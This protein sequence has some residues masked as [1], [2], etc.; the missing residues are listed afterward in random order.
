M[1]KLRLDFGG[2]EAESPTKPPKKVNESIELFFYDT[3]GTGLTERDEVIQIAGF[4]T[5]I[6]LNLKRIV[7]EYCFTNRAISPGAYA[8]HRIDREILLERSK[9]IFL[10]EQ[11]RKDPIFYESRNIIFIAYN[12]KHD[13]GAI[14]STLGNNNAQRLTWGTKI[15]TFDKY[16]PNG[17]YNLDAYQLLR[18]IYNGGRDISLE[19]IMRQKSGVEFSYIQK[20]YNLLTE[21]AGVSNIVSGPHDALFDSFMMFW[22]IYNRKEVAFR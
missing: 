9:G 8:V 4:V 12:D 7:N 20:L 1:D 2:P 3:E 14:N 15:Y 13:K 21:K 16:I 22:L 19:G 11:L 5:D 17:R 10:E 18:N 6:H